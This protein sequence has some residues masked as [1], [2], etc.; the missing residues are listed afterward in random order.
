MVAIRNILTRLGK[1][2][3]LNP[4]RL[5]TTEIDVSP[6]LDLPVVRQRAHQAGVTAEQAV[7][8]VVIELT[9]QLG[10]T[11]RMIVDAALSLGLF[12]ENPPAGVDLDRLYAEHMGKRREYLT[13]QWQS[14]HEALRADSIPPTPTVRQLRGALEHNAFT[15]L[16]GLLAAG[17]QYAIA[18]PYDAPKPKMLV[19]LAYSNAKPGVVTV[20][21]DAVIDHIYRIDHVPRPGKSTPGSFEEHPGGKGLNRAVAAARLGL[22]VRLIATIGDDDRGRYILDYLREENVDTDLVKI[23]AGAQTAVAA[24]MI[25]S[26]GMSSSIGCKDDRVRLGAPDP[27]NP[28]IR[29]AILTSDVV[30]LTFEHAV[31]VIEEVMATM[32]PDAPPL[33]VVDPTPPIDRPQL[34]YKHLGAVDYLVGGRWELERMMGDVNHGPDTDVVRRL[35]SLGVRSVCVL[36]DFGCTVRSDGV[37]VEILP[38]PVALEGSPGAQAA[39]AAALAYRLISSRRSADRQDYLWATAAMVATQSFGDVPGAMPL[40][41]EIDRIVRL[42]SEDR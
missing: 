28:A 22:E 13:E 14:L 11:D 37:D 41:G 36:E 8:P 5:R 23:V 10:P 16:A 34:L 39:F 12:R 29:D 4:D 6:L 2:S 33:L 3:G 1:H 32:R 42:S 17:S 18:L 24:V 9:T 15:A 20:V 25:T 30:L 27:R 19:A 21:G 40:V 38:Y 7:L 31:D 35:R 26:T